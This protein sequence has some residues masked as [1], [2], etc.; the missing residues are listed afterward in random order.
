MISLENSVPPESCRDVEEDIEDTVPPEPELHVEFPLISKEAPPRH[1][2][3]ACPPDVAFL[4]ASEAQW[5][6]LQ[7][8]GIPATSD[9]HINAATSLGLEATQTGP[10]QMLLPALRPLTKPPSNQSANS[11][12]TLLQSSHAMSGVASVPKLLLTQYSEVPSGTT[13]ADPLGEVLD[14]LGR[15]DLSTKDRYDL[16]ADFASL[17]FLG[18]DDLNPARRSQDLQRG[19]TSES[20]ELLADM[21]EAGSGPARAQPPRTWPVKP[22]Q[23]TL[24]PHLNGQC[25]RMALCDGRG[26]GQGTMQTSVGMRSEEED[27]WFFRQQRT[28]TVGRLAIYAAGENPQ[29]DVLLRGGF[30]RP[31]VVAAVRDGGTA[32][33]AG[34]KAGDR[35][36]SINGKKDFSG[37][38][39]D[40]VREMMQSPL[41]LV[42]LGFVG[43]LQAEVRLTCSERI[44]GLSHR[45]EVVRGFAD[46]PVQVC[47]EKV[48]DPSVASLFLVV[49]L[50]VSPVEYPD[51][52]SSPMFEL[53]RYEATD[54]V[55]KAMQKNKAPTYTGDPPAI[56]AFLEQPAPAGD[57]LTHVS[58]LGRENPERD[59][60][61]NAPEKPGGDA[62]AVDDG[63]QGQVLDLDGS[64]HLTRPAQ[65]Q[66]KERLQS[67][68]GNPL[69]LAH[70]QMPWEI[71][72]AVP[73]LT[74]SLS[75]RQESHPL[76]SPR[77]RVGSREL[78]RAPMPSE[79]AM[80]ALPC[81]ERAV[82]IQHCFA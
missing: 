35:L 79:R 26:R 14:W 30:N 25:P 58:E 60:M 74:G 4:S 16:P 62:G 66:D 75:P 11:A 56:S 34:V 31:L 61:T 78:G 3:V 13:A 18:E 15:A 68:G 6:A 67:Q 38:S 39:A 23:A 48:F 17:P 77:S 50:E 57:T 40:A 53:G 21:D 44:C 42:F 32:S 29:E 82:C 20:M 22:P 10:T 9:G 37:L 54:L 12:A 36:V 64:L 28:G 81:L 71:A 7:L 51:L 43:K 45:T 59:S 65:E 47:E 52:Q 8:H 5:V 24:D 19:L 33:R 27:E 70:A 46:A 49:D 76:R 73:V 69:A 41:M 1:P 72:P 2:P 55:H 63:T 80:K